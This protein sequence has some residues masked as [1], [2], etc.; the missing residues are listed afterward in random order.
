M[1]TDDA[2][3]CQLGSRVPPRASTVGKAILSTIS[4]KALSRSMPQLTMKA[5]GDP[6]DLVLRSLA[7]IVGERAAPLDALVLETARKM[8]AAPDCS[9][10]S[11]SSIYG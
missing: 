6:S 8:S 5:Y 4:N 11:A 1:P 9:R 2:R 7:R 3:I 10:M